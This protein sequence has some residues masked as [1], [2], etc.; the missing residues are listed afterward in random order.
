VLAAL[1]LTLVPAW[2]GTS[3]AG[4]AGPQELSRYE[5]V[6]GCFALRSEQ[7]GSWVVKGGAGYTASAPSPAA[8]EPFRM[9]ATDLGRY[10]FYGPAQDVMAR[11]LLNGVAPAGNPSDDSDWTVNEDGDAFRIV[12]G[13]AGRDLAV[14]AAGTLVTVPEGSGGA[15]GRFTVDAVD[16][17]ADYPEVEVNVE[18]G[19]TRGAGPG[20]PVRGFVETHM[21]HMAFEFLGT[22]AHCGRPW[23]RF[24]ARFALVDCPDH[25]D[26]NVPGTEGCAAILE[27]AIS[28]TVCHDTGG[29]PTFAG[30]PHHQQLT[31]EQSYYKWIERAW[32]GGLRIFVNLMVENRVLCELYPL[33]PPTHSCDEMDSVRLQVQ[34]ARELERYIDAQSGGPGEGFYRIVE[35]PGE[36]RRVINEGKLAVVL[37]MEVSEPFGCRLMQ[38]GDM[39]LCSEQQ[40]K[41]GIDELYDLGLRQ[42]E[43]VNKFDNAL[44]GVAGDR[45]EVGLATNT[46]NFLSAGTWWDYETC[47]NEDA[48]LNHDHSPTH[49]PHNDDQLIANGLDLF[50][51][52]T[53][54]T[55]PVY[56]SEPHCNQRGLT[57]LGQVALRR[58]MAKGMLFD[59]DHMSLIA[60]NQALDLIEAEGYPGVM[61]SHSWSTDNA[62]PR[63]SA[64][65]GLIGP[66]AKDPD[67]FVEGWRH[68]RE[69]GYDRMNPYLFGYGYGADMNGFA[70]QGRPPSA[71]ITYPFE[72][73]I[74]PDV[75]IERQ[76]SG[77]KTFDINAEGTAHYGLY[78]DWVEAVRVAAGEDGDEIVRDMAH[79]AEAYLQMWERTTRGRAAPDPGSGGPGP[80]G[81]V[82]PPAAAPPGKKAKPAVGKKRKCAALRAKFKRA[83]KKKAKR[84]LGRKLRAR[85]CAKPK[86]KKKSKKRGSS[87]QK[88]AS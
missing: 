41:D 18:G 4:A 2:G 15:A 82:P 9:Q 51:D 37:G 47:T 53:G 10:L 13:F 1:A 31:H 65:G 79:G 66:A 60:R 24:G 59:P 23:H 22:K 6:H 12:N 26:T 76:V 16:G 54:I 43:L 46:G 38:P 58:I 72:S 39:P 56:G 45:G 75:T 87:K 74:D 5:L 17:C 30:W 81:S 57:A 68:V 40:V 25:G 77:E 21:H 28:G 71:P 80:S 20:A 3:P 83:K 67:S 42:L 14:N 32:R 8:A 70:S 63:I 36:A 52:T 78:A 35:S 44:T 34:R 73:A 48:E 61:T 7:N 27:T 55:P 49:L 33:T 64:L 85:D 88:R 29:W 62:L 84:K 19:P 69:H 11:N 50:G 86:K